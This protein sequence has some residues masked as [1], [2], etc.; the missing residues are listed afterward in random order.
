MPWLED[1]NA[2]SELKV[3]PVSL[4]PRDEEGA[5][6]R[7]RRVSGRHGGRQRA[8]LGWGSCSPE[9]VGE[10]GRGEVVGAAVG[11]EEDVEAVAAVLREGGR[12][13]LAAGRRC[14]G[15]DGHL[16]PEAAKATKHRKGPRSR[17]REGKRVE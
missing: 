16:H 14:W 4:L 8:R 7:E 17:A 11:G 1:A 6:S 15:G 5:A 12:V 10:L 2:P 13:R 3:V 9:G